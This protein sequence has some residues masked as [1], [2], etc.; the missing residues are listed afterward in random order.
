MSVLILS[1]TFVWNISHSKNCVRYDQKCILVFMES[2]H[3]PCQSL[4]KLQFSWQ[5]LKKYSN[6][7]LN[8]NLVGAELFH[9]DGQTDGQALEAN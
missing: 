7:K 5:I 8:E 3:Y 9:A 4:M 2:P 1:T 6:I